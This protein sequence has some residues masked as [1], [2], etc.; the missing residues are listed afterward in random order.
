M[1]LTLDKKRIKNLLTKTVIF[2]LSFFIGMFL[3][4]VTRAQDAKTLL[5]KI[6]GKELKEPSYLYGTIHM[7]CKDDFF[8]TK[9]MQ[10][11]LNETE[12]TI[13][14]LDMD[15]P[16]FMAKMQQGSLNNGMKNIASEFSEEDKE[17]VDTFLKANYGAGLAQLGIVKP[18]GL[19]S[20][21]IQ[22]S[23]TCEA[24]ESYEQNFVKN[25]QEREVELLGLETVEFQ[26]SL[27][28]NVPIKDQIKLL[29]TSIKEFEEGQEDFKKMVAAYKAQD[30][31]KLKKL[32]DE[33]P[34]YTQFEDL[35]INNRNTDWIAKIE[36]HAKEKPTFFAVGAMH[37]A[38]EQG[39]INLLKKEGYQL[40]PVANSID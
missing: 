1:A 14:E 36:K 17:V 31:I 35:L 22:K 25:A 8:F 32:M 7:I 29:V 30:L 15:D 3:A 20:M 37:L 27:F 40:T 16:Q 38:G 13:L 6:E 2:I 24:Q 18:F 33:S 21:V 11:K 26:T 23:V 39:V 5:W 19:L 12:Q 9:T 28:D 34:E 4:R 10:S